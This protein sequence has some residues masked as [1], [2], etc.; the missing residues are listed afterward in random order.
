MRVVGMTLG[1]AALTAW[2]TGRFDAL[3]A[4]IGAPFALPGETAQ[5]AQTR[6]AEGQ[7]QLTEAGL[8]LF[9][10][11]FI[12]AAILCLAALL[13]TAFMAWRR[14]VDGDQ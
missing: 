13:P 5:Q 4:G 12:V 1:I 9:S 7:Q 6:I 2:G 8:T 3:I 11:F 10:D 14:R